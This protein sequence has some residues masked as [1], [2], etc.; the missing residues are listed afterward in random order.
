MKLIKTEKEYDQSLQRLDI[1]FDAKPN[2]KEGQEA[3]LLALLIEE[4]E[5]KNHQI[6]APDPITAIRIRMEELELKQKD[7]VGVIGSKSI[8]SEVLNKKRTLTVNM[9][10]N[11]SDKLKIAS[12]VLIQEYDLQHEKR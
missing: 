10:R 11:L 9:I 5:E 7:L 3:E 2:T 4:Y 12:K 6:V 1:I 8:V